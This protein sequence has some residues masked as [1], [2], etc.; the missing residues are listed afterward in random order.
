M[1]KYTCT[2]V[3]QFTERPNSLLI[4]Y[5]TSDLKR[6]VRYVRRTTYMYFSGFMPRTLQSCR[7]TIIL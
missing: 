7:S 1:V 4:I 5:G 2:T 3:V 6:N